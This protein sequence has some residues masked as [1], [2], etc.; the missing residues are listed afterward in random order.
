MNI[1]TAFLLGIIQGLTEF[2]PVSSSGHLV[3]LRVIF[4]I[5]EPAL[6]FDTMVHVGTLA[7]VV[8]VLRHDILAILRRPFQPLT[9][10][11]VIATIPA[12]IAALFFKNTIERLFET[13]EFLGYAFLVTSLLLFTAELL[14][15]K[16]SRGL[17]RKSS[18][19]RSSI[20]GKRAGIPSGAMNWLDALFIGFLQAIAI[21]PAYHV[22]GLPFP[23]DFSVNLTGIL[24]PVLPSCFQYR[25]FWGRWFCN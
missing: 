22:R 5:S 7:A 17:L 13:G 19:I 25:S 24:P 2:L 9:A 10:Y 12:V 1:S 20:P 11:L 16:A 3:L 21:I 4:G 8:M 14:S 18:A 6:F 15:R 23:A